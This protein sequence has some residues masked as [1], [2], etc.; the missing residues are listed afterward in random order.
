MLRACIIDFG[1]SWD[2]HLSLT[3]FSYN[4]N[5][6]TTIGISP[7]KAMYG[8]KCRT[9][10]CWTETCQKHLGSLEVVREMSEKLDV[11]KER[12]KTAQ[13]RH[14][15]YADNRRRPIE[16]NVGDRVMLKVSPWKGVIRFRKRG[17]LS[18]RF[19]G[20]FDII[21]RV[22]KVAYRL[23]L[24]EELSDIHPTFHVSH[25]RKCLE[26]EDTYVSYED[27]E[28]DKCLNYAERPITILDS[29]EKSLRNK[30]INMVKVQWSNLR[31]SE[32][33]W[34]TEREMK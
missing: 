8:R 21:A 29:K 17:K 3:E 28:V 34:E 25:L 24:P 9:P 16:F 2:S 5:S 31:G 27:I 33:M 14:K 19:I 30:V 26:D 23:N 13:N 22:G 11:I 7:F 1:G 12:M 6:H 18:P 15:S 4:N 32:A 10:V 20:P